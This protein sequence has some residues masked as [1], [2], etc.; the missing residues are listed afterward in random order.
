MAEGLTLRLRQLG[1]AP[2]RFGAAFASLA[3]VVLAGAGAT[4]VWGLHVGGVGTAPSRSP[5]TSGRRKP[6]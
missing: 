3:L 5:S 6:F 4:A 2:D 1:L